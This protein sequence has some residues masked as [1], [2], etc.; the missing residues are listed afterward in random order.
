MTGYTYKIQEQPRAFETRPA[1]LSDQKREAILERLLRC[2]Y[3]RP[4]HL[5][6]IDYS[7]A[8][9]YRKTGPWQEPKA[10]KPLSATDVINPSRGDS[11]SYIA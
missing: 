10:R 11:L 7:I 1:D 9:A 5:G 3:I 6:C 4:I 8:G 2:Q